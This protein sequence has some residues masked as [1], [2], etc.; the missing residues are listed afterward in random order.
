M[1]PGGCFFI[2]DRVSRERALQ[3]TTHLGIGAHPDDLEIMA[4]HGIL[5]CHGRAD[6]WFA[7]ITCTDGSGDRKDDIQALTKLADR[8]RR[9]QNRAASLGGYSFMAQLGFSSAEIQGQGLSR[10]ESELH[11][12]LAELRPGTIYTHNPA[13]KHPTHVAVLQAV[14]TALRLLP[15]DRRPSLLL[16]CEVWRGLD[17]L[18]DEFKYLLPIVDR[19]RLGRRLISVFRS[20]TAGKNYAVAA[21]GRR[22]A[23]ATFFQPR[24]DDRAEQ[25]AFAV[26][27]TSLLED[28]TLSLSDFM[29]PLLKSFENDVLGRLTATS[30]AVAKGK[31]FGGEDQQ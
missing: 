20:Q 17:W 27:L 1:K 15:R 8:R 18:A 29:K 31:R 22:R 4:L 2:P 28:E 12:L 25:L 23:N 7:G 24:Q 3:R 9:E 5:E 19:G 14:L 21:E 6:S 26:D 16:G 30:C 11:E 13:D 10:L